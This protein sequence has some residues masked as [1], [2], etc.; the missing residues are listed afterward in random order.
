MISICGLDCS[1]CDWKDSCRGCAETNSRPFGGEICPLA[2]CS[3]ENGVQSCEKC[4]SR[5]AL[6]AKLIDEFNALAIADM[7]QI[8]ELY[9]LGGPIVN[10]EYPLPGGQTAKFWNDKGIYLGN[11]VH[12]T[13]SERC[14]GLAADEKYLLV[15]EYGENGADPEIVVFKRRK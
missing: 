11:Q 8:T 9:A 15:C 2:K 7:P 3:A 10:M 4:A 12:K 1:R 13:G 6:K 14:Y 5:C